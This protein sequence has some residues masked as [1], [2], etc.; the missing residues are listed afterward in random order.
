VHPVPGMDPV[1]CTPQQGRAGPWFDRLPH[2]RIGFVPS[3]G[4]ELQSEYLVDRSVASEAIAALARIGDA[5]RPALQICELRTVAADGLWMSP[6]HGRDSLALHFTW[7]ADPEAVAAALARIEAEL[8]PLGARPHWGKVFVADAS[9]IA[10]RYPRL[11]DFVALAERLDPR[12]AFANPWL[13]RHVFGP[14]R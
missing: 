14:A 5:I 10:P 4:D 8:L 3:N 7:R 6:S 11:P 12:R 2:F 13:T 1:N 9:A